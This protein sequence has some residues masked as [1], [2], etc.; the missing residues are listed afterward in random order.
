MITSITKFNEY[1]RFLSNFWPV[2]IT[3]DDVDYPTVEHAFQ[4]MKTLS[5][6]ERSIISSLSTPGQAKRYGRTVPLRPQWEEMKVGIMLCLLRQKFHDPVLQK[7]LLDT[8]AVELIEGNNWGDTF[9]GVCNGAGGN[10][11]G[12]LLMKVRKEI[13]SGQG[14]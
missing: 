5:K 4:A 3:I 1:Y 12:V 8:G 7:K 2:K 9:W 10:V 6:L 13:T 11:L 14:G